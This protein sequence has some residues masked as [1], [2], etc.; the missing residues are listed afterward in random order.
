MCFINFVVTYVITLYN[1]PV[2]FLEIK[3]P[4]HLHVISDRVA[5]DDQMRDRF[6]SLKSVTTLF[7]L[8]GISAIGE[9]GFP[10]I[11]WTWPCTKTTQ[12]MSHGCLPT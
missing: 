9:R 1:E 11:V 3:A 6:D 2:V 7:R 8:H 5:A 10:S 4:G 12:H